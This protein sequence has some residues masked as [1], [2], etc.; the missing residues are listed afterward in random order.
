MPVCPDRRPKAGAKGLAWSPVFG[1]NSRRPARGRTG[2]GGAIVYGSRMQSP[3]RRSRA[4]SRR[5]LAFASL[6]IV[7]ATLLA[8]AASTVSAASVRRSWV[9][10][11]AAS[12]G[13][14]SATLTAYWTGNGALGLSLTG[15]Q[16]STTYPIIVYRGTCAAPI[17]ITG[18]PGAVTDAAGA[19]SRSSPVSAGIMNSVWAYARTTS[20]AI[21]IGTG[22][23]GICGALRF[24]TATRVAIPSL[25]IDLPIIKP[26]SAYPP[27]N[28]ALYL[29]ELSQPGEAGVTFI[30]AHARTGMFLPLLDRS[31]ISNGASLLGMTV[32]VWTSDDLVRTYQIT[33]VR[34]HVT[35]LGNALDLEPEQLWLQTSEGP[36]GTVGKLI[37][38][39]KPISVEQATHA[40]AHP[41]ARP[42]T[43][44]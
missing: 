27:C 23:Q 43:C 34:R 10:Q 21:K 9:A 7:V 37:V 19:V 20:I 32:Q 13:S 42:V 11:L 25:K 2:L 1:T 16:P 41:V 22:A 40:A 24:P 29:R 8:S 33:K 31:K 30:Y 12:G 18:L 36:R 3:L 44:G 14:G 6:S 15:L 38:V 28:V 39:A 5:F 26:T 17:K 4:R 35:T